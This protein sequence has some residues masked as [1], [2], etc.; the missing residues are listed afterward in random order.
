[1]LSIRNIQHQRKMVLA[2][3]AVLGALGNWKPLST[4]KNMRY[5]IKT[6]GKPQPFTAGNLCDT[7]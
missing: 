1:M 7:F 2:S 4:L 5:K 3:K 6:L